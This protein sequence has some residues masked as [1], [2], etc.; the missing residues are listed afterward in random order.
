MVNYEIHLVFT[1]S[2][3]SIKGHWS[4]WSIHN[5]PIHTFMY[6]GF[7]YITK[8]TQVYKCFQKVTKPRKMWTPRGKMDLLQ[9]SFII[10]MEYWYEITQTW[11]VL[12]FISIRS[13]F[14]NCIYFKVKFGDENL[15]AG[16][17]TIQHIYSV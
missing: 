5:S 13:L 4:L 1:V 9:N 2:Q 15:S 11:A 17:K 7:Q 8:Y 3:F 6:I 14:M 16:E 12:E 10:D